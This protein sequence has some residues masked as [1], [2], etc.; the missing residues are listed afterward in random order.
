MTDSVSVE[1]LMPS[2]RRKNC[3]A[4]VDID[5]DFD[6]DVDAGYEEYNRE[7]ETLY[8]YFLLVVSRVTAKENI[9]L[10]NTGRYHS[11]VIVPGL[12][13]ASNVGGHCSANYR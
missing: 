8:Q 4:N 1:A 13:V 11:L 3:N 2:N 5:V 10:P 7:A 12:V 6:V 9:A